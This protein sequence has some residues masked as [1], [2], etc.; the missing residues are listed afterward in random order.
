M[1]NKY[2]LET[3]TCSLLM[4]NHTQIK[5][6]LAAIKPSDSLFTCTIV[7]GEILFGIE[8]LPA[9]RRRKALENQATN[10]FAILPCEV[11]PKPAGDHYA[12][13]K[14]EAEKQGTPLDEN[15]LWIAATALALDAILVTADSDF[16][17]ITGLGLR[18][19]DWT[20]TV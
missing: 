19:E 4:A 1:M 17:R 2:L 11:I 7:R 9:G 12:Y 3:S 10:L 6:H 5:T 15:D 8:R 20:K 14:R 13:L 18:L 16:Q